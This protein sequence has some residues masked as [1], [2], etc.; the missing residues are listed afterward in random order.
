MAL[1][2]AA[3]SASRRHRRLLILVDAKA[4]LAA[5]A[6]G[7]SGSHS[8]MPVL[9][10]MAAIQLAADLLPCLIALALLGE[11]PR[12]TVVWVNGRDVQ[13]EAGE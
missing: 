1:D 11:V 4:A 6:K 12:K 8:F 13:R 3:R 7:R 9:R 2:W 5:A 10:Q